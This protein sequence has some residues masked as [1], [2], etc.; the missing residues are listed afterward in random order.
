MFLSRSTH[1]YAY[2]LS[3]F[4]EAFASTVSMDGCMLV[5][6]ALSKLEFIRLLLS[7]LVVH[8]TSLLRTT[9][10]NT[11]L[12]FVTAIQESTVWISR[13]KAE[14]LHAVLIIVVQSEAILENSNFIS[15][16]KPLIES[17]N[18]TST[19]GSSTFSGV[20][21]GVDS[22][23]QCEDSSTLSVLES[24]FIEVSGTGSIFNV[25]ETHTTFERVTINGTSSV[26]GVFGFESMITV[27]ES[28]FNNLRAAERGGAFL[29]H[30]CN[31]MVARSNFSDNQAEEGGAVFFSCKEDE[32]EIT[33]C[34]LTLSANYF[35]ENKASKAGGAL[36]YDLFKPKMTGERNKFSRNKAPY[37]SDIS[38]YGAEI[39]GPSETLFTNIVSGQ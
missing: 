26:R 9:T 13:L 15:A 35:S 4:I 18:G 30:A 28:N 6:N 14:E 32:E 33:D 39:K 17:I 21:L 20:S 27:T 36:S 8:N 24:Q 10:L 19:I 5:D 23:I 16:S 34:A 12:F 22:F 7:H 31:T 37:G 1:C 38:S 11:G 25:Q 2:F 29:L 3:V